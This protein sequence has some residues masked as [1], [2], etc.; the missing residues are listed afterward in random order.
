MH[1]KYFEEVCYGVTIMPL[2]MQPSIF[3]EIVLKGWPAIEMTA[4]D[5][6]LDEI[7]QLSANILKS[8]L[9]IYKVDY[10]FQEPCFYWN[11]VENCAGIKIGML[12]REEY[13]RRMK[14]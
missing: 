14:G 13:E 3:R 11:P 7:S 4:E 2:R 12:E 5:K 8:F 1:R 6:T 10:V 9:N